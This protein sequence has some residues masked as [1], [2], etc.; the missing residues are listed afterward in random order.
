MPFPTN[1]NYQ[2]PAPLINPTPTLSS[3]PKSQVTR[4]LNRGIITPAEANDLYNMSLSELEGD[5]LSRVLHFDG[6]DLETIF[7]R[8]QIW[9][10]A[11]GRYIY[12]RRPFNW[13]DI[14][15]YYLALINA[16][17]IQ[18]TDI[19]SLNSIGNAV[20]LFNSHVANIGISF[21]T[22][23]TRFWL[24]RTLGENALPVY[25]RV[26]AT[27]VMTQN[28]VRLV[29]LVP[30][31]TQVVQ[32]AQQEGTSID[33]LERHLFVHWQNLAHMPQPTVPHN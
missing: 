3:G 7:H 28:S 27:H 33:N 11:T 6:T 19:Q 20:Q 25:D 4:L 32:K 21:I 14:E 17:N 9:G 2:A 22:K 10:G 13:A 15:P 30:Y 16:C 8:I 29:D 5:I 18:D 24:H 23:H 31:W 1:I 26:M 12:V